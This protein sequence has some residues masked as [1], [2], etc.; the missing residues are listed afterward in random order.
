MTLICGCQ[1]LNVL[2]IIVQPIWANEPRR[3]AERGV[4]KTASALSNQSTLGAQALRTIRP[5]KHTQSQACPGDHSE[6]H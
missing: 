2:K 3:P 1:A 6:R 4:K 5:K